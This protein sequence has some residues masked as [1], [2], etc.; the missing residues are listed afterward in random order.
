MRVDELVMALIKCEPET[1]V[2]ICIKGTY[3]SNVVLLKEIE[4]KSA[5]ENDGI[6]DIT[7]IG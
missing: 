3:T 4:Y 1:E 6:E 7:L 5:I 2:L